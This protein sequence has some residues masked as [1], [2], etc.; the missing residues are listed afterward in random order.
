MICNTFYII[1]EA[2]KKGKKSLLFEALKK[3]Q[4]G[5]KALVVGPLAGE[6]FFAASLTCLGHFDKW[7]IKPHSK[8]KW[9][10]QSDKEILWQKDWESKYRKKY[11]IWCNND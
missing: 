10:R 8:T 1:K 9:R 6:L 2:A 11:L 7:R 5:G 3:Q 4:E